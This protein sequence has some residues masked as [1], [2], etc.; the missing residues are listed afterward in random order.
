MAVALLLG[1]VFLLLHCVPLAWP[2]SPV[3][4]DFLPVGA[5]VIAALALLLVVALSLFL[6]A[7]KCFPYLASWLFGGDRESEE[8]NWAHGRL[9]LEIG[10]TLIVL[11]Y[12]LKMPL[13][14]RWEGH[15]RLTISGGWLSGLPVAAVLVA[16]RGNVARRCLPGEAPDQGSACIRRRELLRPWLV[17]LGFLILLERAP[18]LP[19]TKLVLGPSAG[20][21][22]TIWCQIAT[23]LPWTGAVTLILAARPLSRLL[24]FGPLLSRGNRAPG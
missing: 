23:L 19:L 6:I 3:I 10:I 7:P 8:V 13:V 24:S 15:S 1:L 12:A 4:R 11:R 5:R 16:L 22:G 14:W 17:F 2:D 9:L 20:F 18:L 21:E